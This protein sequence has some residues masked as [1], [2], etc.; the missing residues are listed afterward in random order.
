MHLISPRITKLLEKSKIKESNPKYRL[1]RLLEDSDNLEKFYKDREYRK[2]L[3]SAFYPS[4]VSVQLEHILE[5]ER[6][7]KEK[8]SLPQNAIIKYEK[9][10]CSKACRHIHQYYY[11]YLRDAQTK[12]I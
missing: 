6:K 2:M 11:A 3:L 7:V 5:H 12:N 8:L 1:K 10:K 4:L 9:I